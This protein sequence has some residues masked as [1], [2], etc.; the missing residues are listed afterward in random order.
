ML[1]EE[2]VSF[3][4]RTEIFDLRVHW[5]TIRCLLKP[6]ASVIG[7]TLWIFSVFWWTLCSYFSFTT[8][9]S[10]TF[11]LT[12]VFWRLSSVHVLKVKKITGLELGNIDYRPFK[13][14]NVLTSQTVV[15]LN[16]LQYILKGLLSGFN[17]RRKL[18]LDKL[19]SAT[20]RN[21]GFVFWNE[22]YGLLKILKL[23]IIYLKV[24]IL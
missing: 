21:F 3:L 15:I 24:D 1:D 22:G 10:W 8:L 14:Y 5:K 16:F 4:I 9:R 11:Y 18:F 19:Y 2:L 12:G 13:S 20:F 7:F 17:F 6:N 23:L